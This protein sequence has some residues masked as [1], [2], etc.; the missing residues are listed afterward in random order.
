[1]LN[2][3][4]L[5]GFLYDSE[6]K[7]GFSGIGSDQKLYTIMFFFHST[8]QSTP[9]SIWDIHLAEATIFGCP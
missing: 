7:A 6:I 1:M 3:Q 2:T 5:A 4:C 9:S 8:L